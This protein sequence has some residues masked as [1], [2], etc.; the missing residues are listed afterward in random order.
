MLLWLVSSGGQ[1]HPLAKLSQGEVY[2]R[3]HP[4]PSLPVPFR[5]FFL[6]HF[7]PSSER[8]LTLPDEEYGVHLISNSTIQP[9]E[10]IIACPF[11][12]AITPEVATRGICEA[13]NMTENKLVWPRSGGVHAGEGWSGRMRIGAYVGLHL[14]KGDDL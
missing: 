10:P 4:C 5:L 9:R 8:E 13:L 2:S 1:I 14:A 11:D 6:L 12:L 7:L 3:S